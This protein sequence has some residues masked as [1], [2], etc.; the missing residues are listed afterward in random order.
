ME[1]ANGGIQQRRMIRD[2]KLAVV[3]LI[4]LTL[5]WSYNWVVMKTAMDFCGP[6]AFASI[7][8]VVASLVLFLVAAASGRPLSAVSVPGVLLLGVFQTTG[9]FGFAIW[10]LVSGGAGKT[11]VLVYTMPFWILMLAW[12]FLGERMYGWQWLAVGLA[13]AGLVCLFHPWQ[14]HPDLKSSVL[15]CLAGLSW[16]VAGVWNKYFRLRVNV[17]IISLNA[18]QL[19]AGAVPLVFVAVFWEA[20]P[21]DW[22]L[23]LVG[24][25]AYNAVLATALSWTLW[26]FALQ[27]MPAGAAGLGTLAVPVLS[28]FA[29]WIRLGEVPL[30]WEA[31]GMGLVFCGLAVLSGI[32]MA[33]ARRV[34][35]R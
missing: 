7:R 21:I 28:V 14:T 5:V 11:S 10:A 30:F 24:A 15:A 26:F 31:V 4:V 23:Y 8:A 27:K 1:R 18:W 35:A 6:F 25:L 13:F 9:F 29:A 33:A 19:L 32:G 34:P 20:G 16:A 3:G 2:Q 17:D 22:S 12:P